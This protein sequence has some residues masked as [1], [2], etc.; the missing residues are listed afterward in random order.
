[1]IKADYVAPNLAGRAQKLAELIVRECA[2]VC[3]DGN[4]EASSLSENIWKNHCR[5]LILK[6][7]GLEK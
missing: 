3:D 7:F 2:A 5:D 6:H 4:G 1:M